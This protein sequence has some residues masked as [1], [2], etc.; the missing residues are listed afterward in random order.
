MAG[1][2]FHMDDVYQG[3]NLT[4][5]IWELQGLLEDG[6]IRCGNNDLLKAHMLD[7]A[8]KTN[9]MTNKVKLVKVE[10]RAHIDGMA[11]MLDAMPVRQKYYS[12]IGEQLK[13]AR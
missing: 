12:E 3:E 10:N 4:P 8:L 5:V 13:N 2:G 7:S 11:A 9:S 6:R 1:Y